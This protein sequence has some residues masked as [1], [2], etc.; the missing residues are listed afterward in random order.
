MCN[1]LSTAGILGIFIGMQKLHQCFGRM[2]VG[3]HSAHVHTTGMSNIFGSKNAKSEIFLIQMSWY[4]GLDT[5]LGIKYDQ[6]DMRTKD[7]K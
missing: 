3:G 1:L 6:N 5:F 7:K 2:S 4:Y